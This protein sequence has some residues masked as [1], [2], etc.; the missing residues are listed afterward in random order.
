MPASQGIDVHLTEVNQREPLEEHETKKL[1]AEY[2]TTSIF[3]N[4][5]LSVDSGLDVAATINSISHD[6][7]ET[8]AHWHQKQ[9]QLG[10]ARSNVRKMISAFESSL[11]QVH[12]ACNFNS[13]VPYQYLV[14]NNHDS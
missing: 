2:P 13:I 12:L 6:L 10:K 7:E 11:S 1:P 9:S 8:M 4:G 5:M 14:C 3:S